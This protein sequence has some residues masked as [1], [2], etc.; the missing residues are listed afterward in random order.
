MVCPFVSSQPRVSWKSRSPRPSA[1]VWRCDLV[2]H[3]PLEGAERVEVLDLDLCPEG[4]GSHRPDR[5]VPFD[6]HASRLHVG[7]RGA[8]VTQDVAQGLSV[9]TRLRRGANVRLGHDLHERDPGAVEVHERESPAAMQQARGV[10]LEV[11]AGDA[12][13]DLHVLG[14][15][16]HRQPPVAAQRQGVLA[17]LV[18]LR[19]VRIEVVLALEA[20]RVGLDVAVKREPGQDHQL[21]G[22]TVDH[23]QRAG[24]GQADGAD[25][26]VRL[27][28]LALRRGR[29]AGAEHLRLGPQLRVD[30]DPDDRLV[31]RADGHGAD[32]TG[33]AGERRRPAILRP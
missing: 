13:H 32:C 18:T 8:D 30:L 21:H 17:D 31:S 1:S 19:E 26:G 28:R 7:V 27:V 3:G 9:G 11:G 25:P 22:A 12:H 5:D 4:V 14:C 24:Q 20:H 29:P 2:L 23:G 16:R 6:A 10:L 33:A 15:D